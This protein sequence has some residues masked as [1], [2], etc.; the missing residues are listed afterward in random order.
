MALIVLCIGMIGWAGL[1]ANAAW[2]YFAAQAIAEPLFENGNGDAEAF[3]TAEH[4]VNVAL[5]RLPGN[6][7]YHDFAGRLAI[8][9]AGQ[10]G[11]VG[12]ERR[13][14]LEGAANNFRQACGNK[15]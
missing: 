3:A 12:A 9:K 1:R 10:P 4:N 11:V 14:I 6:P 2:H 8:L 15:Y 13:A 5:Q 7:D